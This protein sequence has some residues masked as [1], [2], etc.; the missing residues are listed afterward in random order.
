MSFFSS[1][2]SL[3]LRRLAGGLLP[4]LLVVV[5]FLLGCYEMADSD[6]WWHLSGGRRSRR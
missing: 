5:A 3:D 4:A 6:V 1:L 2:S